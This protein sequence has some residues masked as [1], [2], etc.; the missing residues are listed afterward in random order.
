[1]R[2]AMEYRQ[3]RQR[4]RLDLPTITDANIRDLLYESDL[5]VRSCTATGSFGPLSPFEFLRIFSTLSELFSQLFVLYSLS[6]AFSSLSLLLVLIFPTIST[7][8]F[9]CI[10]SYKSNTESIFT[11]EQAKASGR[12]EQMRSMAYSEFHKSEIL[13]FNLGPWILQTWSSARKELLGLENLG[14]IP[15]SN[16]FWLITQSNV[17]D[18]LMLLQNV[19][20]F[21]ITVKIS[22]R[23][24][25]SYH[26]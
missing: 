16:V 20:L 10:P 2:Y 6:R 15:V 1:M 18:F 9:S 4:L 17:S 7:M 14:L 13:F 19:C 26:T 23:A 11:T 8:L 25:C 3:M 22:D 5:F 24:T 21:P 12:Q